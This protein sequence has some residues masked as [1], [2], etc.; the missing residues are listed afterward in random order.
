MAANTRKRSAFSVFRS[1]SADKEC[2]FE[3]ASTP[4]IAAAV[5]EYEQQ[6]KSVK[7]N[8]R[9][10]RG[11]LSNFEYEGKV[12]IFNFFKTLNFWLCYIATIHKVHEISVGGVCG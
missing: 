1:G 8:K 12:Q 5:S 11:S 10:R 3:I 9:L 4:N 7:A 6:R 2:S